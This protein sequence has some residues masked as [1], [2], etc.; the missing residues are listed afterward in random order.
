MFHWSS[1]L[2]RY[3]SPASAHAIMM[4]HP[5]ISERPI[6]CSRVD[7]LRSLPCVSSFVRGGPSRADVECSIC[8]RGIGV[9]LSPT[10]SLQI[11]RQAVYMY[12]NLAT[13]ERSLAPGI[14]GWGSP[15]LLRDAQSWSKSFGLEEGFFS[16]SNA[17]LF[18]TVI[19]LQRAHVFQSSPILLSNFLDVKI[20]ATLEPMLRGFLD[21][22][23]ST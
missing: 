16:G 1:G 2:L 5:S 7:I 9:H 17:V 14:F 12:N 6:P 3:P 8:I 19:V 10:S 11:E 22:P 15:R 23:P 20:S 18:S 21:W 13:R 4:C